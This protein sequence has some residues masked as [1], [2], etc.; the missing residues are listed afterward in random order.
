M[1]LATAPSLVVPL[2]TDDDDVTRVGGTRVMLDTV[3]FA[4]S[5]GAPPEEII[6]QYDSLK[7]ADVYVVVDYYLRVRDVQHEKVRLMNETRFDPSGIRDRLLARA[8]GGRL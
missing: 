4:Y 8:Q 2:A 3:L 1:R 7:L 5:Q 6:E